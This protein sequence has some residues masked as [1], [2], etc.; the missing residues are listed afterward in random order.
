MKLIKDQKDVFTIPNMLSAF[1]IIL[2]AVF[3][4]VF[5]NAEI[6]NQKEILTIIVLIS[7]LTDFLDGK[8]ARRFNMVSELGKILDPIADKITQGILILCLMKK[9][10]LLS[11]LFVFFIIKESFMG[12]AGLQV[13]KKTGQNEGAMWYGKV[14]TAI[15]YFVM[16]ILIFIPNISIKVANTLIIASGIFMLL[17]FILYAQKFVSLLKKKI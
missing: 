8:I 6:S 1:R 7:A 9:Y 10:P 14:S 2:A 4:C 13:L 5:R 3:L 16:L 17:S 11:G 15:F 12:I